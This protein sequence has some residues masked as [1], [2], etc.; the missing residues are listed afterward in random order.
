MAP[1]AG[2]RKRIQKKVDQMAQKPRILMV[3]DDANILASY[4]RSLRKYF[5]VSVADSAK[6]GL[7]LCESSAPFSVIITDQNMPGVDGTEFL[8]RLDEVAKLPTRIMLTGESD[9]N[10]AVEAVNKGSI[11]RFLT[12][13]CT[14]DELGK[15]IQQGINQYNLVQAEKELIEK[16]LMGSLKALAEILS[17][18]NPTAFGCTIRVR[19]L[20]SRLS[21]AMDYPQVANVE[22]AALVY[23]L[24]CITIDEGIIRNVNKGKTL[25]D[26]E[27]AE[28]K[29]H[30]ALASRLLSRIPR[31]E[32]VS[33]MVL[34]QLHTPQ[35]INQAL[36]PEIAWGANILKSCIEF[37]RLTELQGLSPEQAL[38][39]LSKEGR[40]EAKVIGGLRSLGLQS[41]QKGENIAISSLTELKSNMIIVKD[42]HAGSGALLISKG[43]HVTASLIARLENVASRNSIQFPL[44]VNTIEEE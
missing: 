25:T 35:E 7:R 40:S 23:Q 19:K 12:K 38:E 27:L 13:P 44:F 31:L 39:F 5:D 11:F 3:D 30:P 18:S 6:E 14:P 41:S 22:I 4:K 8:T 32:A 26:G 28:W 20:V 37:D 1:V 21:R 29:N 36:K 10:R 16:T 42:I 2:A 43:H 17:L 24:G 15:V 34:Y 9:L 33:D